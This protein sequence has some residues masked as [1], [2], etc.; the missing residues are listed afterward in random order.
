MM[1]G[2]KRRS[3]NGPRLWILAAAVVLALGLCLGLGLGLKHRHHNSAST[4]ALPFLNPQT[5]SHFVVGSIVGQSPQDRNYNF[6]LALANGAPDGVNKTM[7]VVN[8]TFLRSCRDHSMTAEARCW[9]DVTFLLAS[10]FLGCHP[11]RQLGA[12][13]GFWHRIYLLSISGRKPVVH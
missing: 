12:L 4:E 8:G 11:K 10:C 3:L 13:H 5:S 1:A 7:L 2:V 6:T 9:C